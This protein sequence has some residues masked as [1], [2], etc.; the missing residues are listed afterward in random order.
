MTENIVIYTYDE[1]ELTF[2]T[3]YQNITVIKGM[4]PMSEEDTD[5]DTIIELLNNLPIETSGIGNF[6]TQ[7]LNELKFQ[8]VSVSSPITEDTYC[9]E[10]TVIYGNSE[11]DQHSTGS[12]IPYEQNLSL[13][14]NKYYWIFYGNQNS[15]TDIQMVLFKTDTAINVDDIDFITSENKSFFIYSCPVVEGNNYISLYPNSYDDATWYLTTTTESIQSVSTASEITIYTISNSKFYLLPTLEATSENI[16]LIPDTIPIT[17][18]N[19]AY[20]TTIDRRKLQILHIGSRT[21]FS[22]VTENTLYFAYT[23]SN[24]NVS[25][26]T[27]TP[28]ESGMSLTPNRVYLILR[29]DPTTTSFQI[30]YFIPYKEDFKLDDMNWNLDDNG[31]FFIYSAPINMQNYY[32]TPSSS[33]VTLPDY[34]MSLYNILITTQTAEASVPIYR[35]NEIGLTILPQTN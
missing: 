18:G 11:S 29:G 10:Y 9:S 20:L 5:Y 14:A 24:N 26:S 19:S 8:A 4:P 1:D 16:Q 28:Y 2:Q 15:K 30:S 23:D 31:S 6:V 33:Q 32:L 21:N 35:A 22:G 27:I 25:V 34:Y 7:G 12:E 3:P 17:N 13:D